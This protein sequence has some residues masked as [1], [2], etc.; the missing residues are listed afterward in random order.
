MTDISNRRVVELL[1]IN[2]GSLSPSI[3]VWYNY[4]LFCFHIQCSFSILAAAHNASY[5]KIAIP[6]RRTFYPSPV[7]NCPSC[8]H[9]CIQGTNP[10]LKRIY[11]N[12]MPKCWE[13]STGHV[14]IFPKN[15]AYFVWY[16]GL[17]YLGLWRHLGWVFN[18]T[19]LVLRQTIYRRRLLLVIALVIATRQ[20]IVF[21]STNEISVTKLNFLR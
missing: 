21:M 9:S 10:P 4:L 20:S 11:P 1:E 8:R 12:C 18:P 2:S 3:P 17:K 6:T 14:C 5:P 13:R 16:W 19:V 7:A 15:I